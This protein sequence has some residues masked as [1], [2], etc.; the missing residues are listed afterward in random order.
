MHYL[1]K[2]WDERGVF[3]GECNI[4]GIFTCEQ[5]DDLLFL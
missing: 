4:Q 2:K 1:V 5:P 3:D